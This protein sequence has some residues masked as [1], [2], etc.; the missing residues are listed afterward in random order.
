MTVREFLL[1]R[2]FR[3]SSGR[4]KRLREIKAPYIIL[5]N[6]LETIRTAKQGDITQLINCKTPDVFDFEFKESIDC[7]GNG[8]KYYMTIL[9]STETLMYFPQARFGR[10]LTK[11]E[12]N[13]S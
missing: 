6:E 5:K 13:Q 8:G 4:L 10:Y 3:S 9:T 12:T 11:Q 2:I 1:D 7:T